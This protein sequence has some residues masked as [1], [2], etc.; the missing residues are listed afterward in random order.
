VIKY[1]SGYLDPNPREIKRFVRVFRFFVMIYM[2]RRLRGL[3]APASLKGVAKLAV[4]AIRW[5]G[6]MA[7]LAESAGSDGRTIFDTLE[8]PPTPTRRKNETKKT[9]DRRVLVEALTRA[10]VA[11]PIRDRLLSSELREFMSSQPRLG[12]AARGYL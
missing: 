11:K 6:L 4:L 9:A 5:P 10:G 3:R 12:R 7:T 8:D 2:E 1:A